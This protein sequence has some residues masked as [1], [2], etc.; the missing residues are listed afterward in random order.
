MTFRSLCFAFAWAV[1]NFSIFGQAP[2]P[3]S[4]E[5]GVDLEAID[6]SANPCNNFFQYACGSWIK[7]HPIPADESRYGRFNELQDRNLAILRTILEESAKQQNRSA[8]DQK[9]GGFYQ[10]CMN[11]PLIEQKGKA[12]LLPELE[13]ISDISNQQQLEDEVAR[14]QQMQVT[15]FFNFG[16]SPDLND[17]RM[18]IGDLDQGGLGLPE[19]DYYF[20]TDPKSQEIRQKYVAH[21]EKLYEFIGVAEPDAQKKAA[22]VMVIE[23]VLAKASLDVTSRRDPQTLNHKMSRSE[24]AQLSPHFDFNRFFVQVETPQFNSLNV[25]VPAFMKALSDVVGNT[26]L[27]D[28]KDYLRAH[29]ISSS[30]RL[31][32]KTFVTENFDFYSR[33]LAGVKELKPRWKRCVAATDDELGDALGRKFVEKTFGEQGKQ[34][35]MA[36]VH[37][38]EKQ[39]GN[40]INSIGW[41][42]P[43]TKNQAQIKLRAVADKIGYPEKWKDYATVQ[44]NGDDYFGNWYRANEYESKRQ[45]DKIG[46]PVDRTEWAMSAPTVNA[47]YDPTQNNINFPAGILQP[48]F[49]SNQFGNA[50][51]YGA[52]GVVIGHELTHGFDD[53]GRQF[54]AEGNLKDWW[55]KSDEEQFT[56]LADCIVKEYG[57]F[58][59]VPGVKV[60]G[61]LTLGENT[62][63]NGGIRLAYMALLDDLAK[64]SMSLTDKV[65]GYTQAQQ[66]FVGFG[67]V[68]C[69]NER[70]E[71]ARMS[72]QT[73]P[74]SP[75]EFRVNGVVSN[76]QQFSEAFGCKE[77]DKMYAANA[78]RVW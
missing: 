61:K 34:R 16:S 33:T 41:M 64:K 38:I 26:K 32:P 57:A 55:R 58:S 25:D 14:L 10:S 24:L 37:E 75:P 51:N 36:M 12:P 31:L 23:T 42:T 45:R 20:R 67:Q 73:D 50:V 59:P 76:M 9:I 72:V 22:T 1:F 71:S 5:S 18:V 27:D 52:I 78:C 48:P 7:N 4:S 66:Y 19:R 54:D 77:G 65:D 2:I 6:K 69:E 39:M 62:A 8:I 56:K 60:N 40:D 17:A 49:Y 29:Y 44:I 47:Y 28:L 30:A 68:W 21:L 13:R 74:H 11:E 63:D 3:A 15:V 46:K 35:T 70:P 53:E 43:E